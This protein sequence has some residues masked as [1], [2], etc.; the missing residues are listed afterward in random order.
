MRARVSALMC[1]CAQKREGEGEAGGMNIE[2][3]CVLHEPPAGFGASSLTPSRPC[4]CSAAQV[5]L[6]RREL[7]RRRR[8]GRRQRQRRPAAQQRA[9]L[10]SADSEYA[11]CGVFPRGAVAATAV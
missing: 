1:A 5:V 3:L 2:H 9:A 4:Q 6:R 10:G 11:V 8:R 7:R